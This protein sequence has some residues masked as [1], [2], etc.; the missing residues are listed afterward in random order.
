[1]KYEFK[2]KKCGAIRTV[3]IEMSKISEA[4][5]MCSCGSEMRRVWKA[6]LIIPDYM[7][8]DQSQEMSYINDRLNIR[9]SGKTK[10]YY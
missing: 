1:M 9:P 8:A 7:K 6:S 10:V 2:C 4:K 3:D 5:I